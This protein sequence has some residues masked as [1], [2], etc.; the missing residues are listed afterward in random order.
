MWPDEL[1]MIL[2]VALAKQCQNIE[3]RAAK[4]NEIF[5]Y[6]TATFDEH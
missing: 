4:Q 2:K 1:K 5:L 6:I 3:A